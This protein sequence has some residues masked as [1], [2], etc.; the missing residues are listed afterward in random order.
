MRGSGADFKMP[1]CACA[2]GAQQHHISLPA[3]DYKTGAPAAR[4]RA[5]AAFRRSAA[6]II[7]SIKGELCSDG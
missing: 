1:P 7:T 4:R 2:A 5:A 6:A 3:A